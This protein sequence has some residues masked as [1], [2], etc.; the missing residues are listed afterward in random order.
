MAINQVMWEAIDRFEATHAGTRIVPASGGGGGYQ[1]LMIRVMEG[2]PPDIM[3]FATAETGLTY[4]YVEQGH[5]LD[6]TDFINGP[7]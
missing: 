3:S 1:E 2:Q 5:V 4:A 6:M 7:S